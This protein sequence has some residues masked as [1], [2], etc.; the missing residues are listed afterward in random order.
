MS[1]IY[2]LY[3]AETADR[4]KQLYVDDEES[5]ELLF[6]VLGS[7]ILER[8]DIFLDIKPLDILTLICSTAQFT[9]DIY[10]CQQVALI[11]DK[12]IKDK[13]PLPYI[14]DDH[15]IILA[16]K[17]LI[18]LSFHK[19]AMEHRTKYNGAPTTKF[20][21]DCSKKILHSNGFGNI[22]YHHEQWELFLSEIFI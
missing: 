1:L 3:E 15:G 12:R 22:A 8:D 16:E 21:R 19:A 17:T 10:E 6:S 5:R 2:K 9:D 20:Y 13:N 14:L 11:I 18:A 4:I 7:R